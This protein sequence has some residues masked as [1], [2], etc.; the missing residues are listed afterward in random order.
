MA[1]KRSEHPFAEGASRV[2][3]VA[4]VSKNSKSL[5]LPASQVVA[6]AF[7]YVGGDRNHRK[8]YIKEME[9]SAVAEFLAN[10]YNVSEHRPGHCATIK[11]LR[12]RVVEH[13][14]ASNNNDEDKCTR[15]VIESPLQQG[16]F[17]K[18]GNNAGIWSEV[19][20]TLLRFS[21]F[22][23]FVTDGYMMVTDLQGVKNRNE[24]ELTDPVILCR[25]VL[26]FGEANLGADFIAKCLH[27][28]K[29]LMAEN[30]WH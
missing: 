27:S 1:M 19:D 21:V 3:F 26:R 14:N 20:E 4:Q 10:L 11:Y 30:G 18:F 15:Y 8:H 25:D 17:T 22:T 6:K 29:A 13:V 16:R 7:R 9:S 2:A 24:F 5:S 23:H 28:T 12:A